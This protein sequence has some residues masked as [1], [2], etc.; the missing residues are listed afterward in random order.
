MSQNPHWPNY[1]TGP[2]DSISAMGVVSINFAELESVFVFMFATILKMAHDTATQIVAKV[3][4]GS[5]LQLMNQ[6]LETDDWTENIRNEVGYFAK[7]LATC[8]ENRNHLMHSN[9]SWFG[10]DNATVLFKT[11]KQGRTIMAVLKTA[12]LQQ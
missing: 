5:C 2:K 11:S 9:L 12:D 6:V 3:G 10:G 1:L 7:G 4:A 8:M